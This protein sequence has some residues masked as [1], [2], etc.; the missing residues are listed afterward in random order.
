MRL[1]PANS[2]ILHVYINVCCSCRYGASELHSV[3]SFMG[4]T[5]A[6]EVIKLLTSQFVPINNTFIYNAIKQT[7]LT[8]EL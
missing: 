4:G 1:R 8:V 6:Q 7:S 3:A 2:Q 5:A